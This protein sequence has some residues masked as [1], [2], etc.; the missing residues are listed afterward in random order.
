MRFFTEFVK[1]S[2]MS[3]SPIRFTETKTVDNRSENRSLMSTVNTRMATTFN[4]MQ[5]LTPYQIQAIKNDGEVL[6]KIILK[7]LKEPKIL[8]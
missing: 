2:S 7:R 8:I 1:L 4:A 6:V 3:G 5:T